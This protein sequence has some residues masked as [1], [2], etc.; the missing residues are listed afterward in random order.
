MKLNLN[1]TVP[2]YTPKKGMS[3]YKSEGPREP[4]APQAGVHALNKIY[5]VFFLAVNFFFPQ[6]AEWNRD[7]LSIQTRF[8]V[9]REQKPHLTGGTVLSMMVRKI[10]IHAVMVWLLT[11]CRGRAY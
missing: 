8:P 4:T 6:T 1:F 2:S 11:S 7:S 3:P 10:S 5:L 9:S